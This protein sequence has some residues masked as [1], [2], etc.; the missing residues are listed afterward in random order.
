MQQKRAKYLQINKCCIFFAADVVFAKKMSALAC[1]L[2]FSSR[3]NYCNGSNMLS[4]KLLIC[5]FLK[6]HV[7]LNARTLNNQ[8][9]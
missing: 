3:P 6:M 9:I 8:I 1:F 7:L 4:L 2:L 5:S